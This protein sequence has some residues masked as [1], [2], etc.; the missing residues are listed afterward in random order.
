MDASPI[1][2]DSPRQLGVCHDYDGLH[3]ILRDRADEL[4]VS[5]TT[6]DEAAGFTPGHASKLL[7][8]R[9]LKNLGP[10]SLGLML[11]VM[12]LKLVVVEDAEALER[13]RAKLIPREI[14]ANV[15]SLPWA[16]RH[17]AKH[18]LVSKRWVRKI[19]RK[20]GEQRAKNLSPR[21]R[22]AIA[23]KAAKARWSRP[24]VTEITS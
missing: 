21:Q 10:V 15:L 14:P 22:S 24:R 11:Q 2:T 12:G 4:N 7:S 6:L 9:P 5:R 8:P 16:V 23:R 3:R 13:I 18:F 1:V 19:G 17:G 20:G